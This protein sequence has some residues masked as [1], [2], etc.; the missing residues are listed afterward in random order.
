MS[1]TLLGPDDS[2]LNKT[3]KNSLSLGVYILVEEK[4]IKDDILS[5]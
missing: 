5:K 1:G 2:S 4:E 3:D